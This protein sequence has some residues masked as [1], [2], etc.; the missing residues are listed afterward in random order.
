MN[1]ER[2]RV[3]TSGWRFRDAQFVDRLP[4]QIPDLHILELLFF[5]IQGLVEI[6]QRTHYLSSL[7]YRCTAGPRSIFEV[8][9]WP[10]T[11]SLVQLKN[12]N[13]FCNHIQW[14]RWKMWPILSSIST[15]FRSRSLA[16]QLWKKDTVGINIACI[17]I[18]PALPLVYISLASHTVQ[19]MLLLSCFSALITVGNI[20]IHFIASLLK[21]QRRP[22]GE[23]SRNK[24][25]RLMWWKDKTVLVIWLVLTLELTISRIDI[26]NPLRIILSIWMSSPADFGVL[27]T[28]PNVALMLVPLT[29][30]SKIAYTYISQPEITENWRS[31]PSRLYPPTIHSSSTRV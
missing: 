19:S 17:T 26:G 14:C 6:H 1:W 22:T 10:N 8:I 4:K 7:S 27:G 9:L 2:K 11:I 16:F 5:L 13:L 21:S 20:W 30:G 18:G 23:I 25:F 24:K 28:K 12:S 31:I 3:R 29:P 15:H